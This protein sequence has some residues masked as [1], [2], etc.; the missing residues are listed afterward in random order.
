MT[1]KLHLAQHCCTLLFIAFFTATLC[2]QS[3]K[4]GLQT[5]VNMSGLQISSHL[6]LNPDDKMLPGSQCNLF[7]EYK[8]GSLP[9]SISSEPGVIQKGFI[10]K[11]GNEGWYKTRL[12]YLNLPT[13]FNYYPGKRLG[14]SIGAELNYLVSIV[15]NGKKMGFS[16]F[17]YERTE[18]AGTARLSYR[19]YKKWTLGTSYTMGITPLYKIYTADE[20][21]MRN[22]HITGRNFST[23]VYV[24]YVLN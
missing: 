11:N 13:V 15:Q 12:N 3:I 16:D 23:Q 8:F 21:G 6:D 9:I 2:G 1:S 10:F 18:V 17:R 14:V 5:G 22:G 4:M 19:V 20:N 7:F 24:R